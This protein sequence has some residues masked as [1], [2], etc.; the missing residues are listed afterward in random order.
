MRS[1]RLGLSLGLDLLGARI[2]SFDCLYCEVGATDALTLAQKPY[3]PA[4]RLLGEL[5]AFAASGPPAFDVVTLGGLGE[6]CLNTGMGEIIAGCREIFPG[7][8]VAVLTNS[9]LL[10]HAAVR[11]RL[12]LA[13]IVLPSM[14]TL[15]PGEFAAL[16]RPHPDLS[17]P[18]IRR[19]LLDFRTAFSGRLCLETLI[20]GG[21]NDTAENLALLTDFCRG[22]RPDRVDVVTM[23]RPGAYAAAQAAA[24]DTLERFRAVLGAAVTDA[25]M[26][27]GPAALRSRTGDRTEPPSG[28]AAD[29]GEIM[30]RVAASLGRRPQTVH[31]LSVA[32]GLPED[33]ISR[34]VETLAREKKIQARAELDHVFYQG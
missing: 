34:A 33:D 12:A 22:L 8:P 25:G 4:E 11:D 3:V 7:V 19:G 14:D 23:T 16:N 9:S 13:D 5:S 20:V 15:V 26:G 21:I 29:P 32:L 24:P 31:Q 6:P 27:H 17:L 10:S 28:R 30:A 18:A 2:C 1:G